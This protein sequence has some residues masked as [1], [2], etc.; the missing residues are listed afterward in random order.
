MRSAGVIFHET[1][2]SPEWGTGVNP[3]IVLV[4]YGVEHDWGLPANGDLISEVER[5]RGVLY[6]HNLEW[7]LDEVDKSQY[8]V[9]NGATYAL[10][11]YFNSDLSKLE[12]WCRTYVR[13]YGASPVK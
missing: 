7:T 2:A 6:Q 5:I 13:V 10:Y 9:A 11:R 1:S 8:P 12:S 4:T 3:A